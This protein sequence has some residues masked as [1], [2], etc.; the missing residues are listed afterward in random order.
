MFTSTGNGRPSHRE[1]GDRASDRLAVGHVRRRRDCVP[2]GSLDERARLVELGRRSRDQAD[3]VAAPRQ[4]ERGRPPD[5][6]TRPGDDR[7]TAIALRQ[8]LEQF[9][10]LERLR[11]LTN[12]LE[13]EPGALG[14]REQVVRAVREV[15]HPQVGGLGVRAVGDALVEAASPE[16]RLPVGREVPVAPVGL[17]DVD[18]LQGVAERGRE[19]LG[20]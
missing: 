14:D 8:P 5:P 15:Q 1:R 9:V 7:Q 6:A 12:G 16:L 20:R 17:D 11:R 4:R 19:R 18:D 2:A 3:R 13:R 10:L